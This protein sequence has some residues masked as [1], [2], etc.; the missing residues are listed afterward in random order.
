VLIAGDGEGKVVLELLFVV[1]VVSVEGRIILP[2]TLKRAGVVVITVAVIL[3]NV[4]VP[5]SC[6][7]GVPT[8]YRW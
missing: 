4:R 2:G 6:V 5:V 1:L 3:V 8:A 7:C